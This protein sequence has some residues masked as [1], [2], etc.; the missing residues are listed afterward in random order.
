MRQAVVRAGKIRLMGCSLL[1]TL[2][3]VGFQEEVGWAA[4]TEPHAAERDIIRLQR[5]VGRGEPAKPAL[6]E[7]GSFKKAL[8]AELQA[9]TC[10]KAE[11][12]HVFTFLSNELI[13]LTHVW[14]TP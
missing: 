5:G 4:A 9:T 8:I 3:S 7:N 6:E 12:K 1:H 2:H 14:P 13:L 10:T 11:C